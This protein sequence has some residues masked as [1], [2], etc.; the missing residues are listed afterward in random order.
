MNY[1]IILA[2]G[3]GTRTG[4]NIPKQYFEINDE[5]I[6]NFLL[7]NIVDEFDKVVFVCDPKYKNLL[8]KSNKIVFAN[9]GTTRLESLKNGYRE[10]KKIAKNGDLIFFHEAARIFLDS[11]D[12]NLHKQNAKIGQGLVTC[13]KV[14][15]TMFEIDKNNNIKNVIQ[16]NDIL[17]GY[18][19]QSYFYDDLMKFDD[20]ILNEKY[21]LDL[22]KILIDNGL[23]IKTIEQISNLRKITTFEDIMWIKSELLNEK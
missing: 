9:N 17:S 18:N 23:K 14:F 7:K 20:K 11:K 15:D 16:K 12:I 10:I 19:P 13:G 3:I 8:L 6:S 4:L 22:T 5:I 1:I 21:D 2:G